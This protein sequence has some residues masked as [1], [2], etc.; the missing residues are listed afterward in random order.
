[1]IGGAGAGIVLAALYMYFK[2]RGKSADDGWGEA[3]EEWEED[4]EEEELYE[5]PLR[6]LPLSMQ[7]L[8]LNF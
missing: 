2:N 4:W 3:E 7:C 6:R 8:N 1:M 5:V